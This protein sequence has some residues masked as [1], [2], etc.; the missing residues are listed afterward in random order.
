MGLLGHMGPELMFHRLTKRPTAGRLPSGYSG[1]PV[2]TTASRYRRVSGALILG[3]LTSAC[4]ST[5]RA[6]STLL[7]A[8]ESH[9]VVAL[10]EGLHGN[11][12]AHQFRLALIRDPRFARVVND[13]VVEFGTSRYQHVM[14][15]FIRGESVPATDLRKTWQDTMKAGAIWDAPIYEEFFRAVRAVNADLPKDRQLRV[16]LADPPIEWEHVHTPQDWIA[17]NGR[18]V[19]HVANLV[20]TEVLRRNRRALLVFGDGHYLRKMEGAFDGDR[21]PMLTLRNQIE[22]DDPE[23]VFSIWTN[24]TAP[25]EL[26]DNSVSSWPVPRLVAMRGTNLGR[27]NF[28]VIGGIRSK[29]RVEDQYDA[30]L[31]VGP[32]SSITISELPVELCRDEAYM[33]MRVSRLAVMPGGAEEVESFKNSCAQRIRNRRPFTESH[34]AS[35]GVPESRR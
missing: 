3:L 26:L 25:L 1:M 21:K 9:P 32:P 17:W 7:D 14:D 33:T 24:T 34:R 15:A 4:D 22:R 18:G 19:A 23:S 31:Y 11:E 20:R 29:L 27:L 10:G 35:T 28:S 2:L 8:F 6:I 30:V 12:Q 13:I 16:L 5:P